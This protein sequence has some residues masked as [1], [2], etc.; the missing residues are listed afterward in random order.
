[1]QACLR[2]VGNLPEIDRAVVGVDTVAQLNQIVEATEGE[3]KDLPEFNTLQDARLIN[4]ASWSQ[5]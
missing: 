5:L 2:Y 3:L 4:P 1:L